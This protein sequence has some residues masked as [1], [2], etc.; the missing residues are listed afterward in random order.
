MSIFVLGR[1]EI[2]VNFCLDSYLWSSFSCRASICCSRSRQR[3]SALMLCDPSSYALVL[4]FSRA[5]IKRPEVTRQLLVL[6]AHLL[7]LGHGKSLTPWRARHLI[8]CP[9]FHSKHLNLSYCHPLLI[10]L[11]AP[12]VTETLSKGTFHYVHQQI[13]NYK[14]NYEHEKKNRPMCLMWARR[15]HLVSVHSMANGDWLLPSSSLDDR[16]WATFIAPPSHLVKNNH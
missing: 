12:Q 15:M 13:E 2:V 10:L 1:F 8:L 11:L 4:L 14:D 6:W 3:P 5:S 9:G 16:I 7:E